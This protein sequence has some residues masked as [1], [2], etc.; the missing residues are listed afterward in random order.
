[1]VELEIFLQRHEHSHFRHSEELIAGI[2]AGMCVLVRTPY[3][4]HSR[5]PL[6]PCRHFL[7]IYRYRA[8]HLSRYQTAYAC[9]LRED[10]LALCDELGKTLEEPVQFWRF[11]MARYYNFVVFEDANSHRILGCTFSADRRLMSEQEWEE[12][13]GI[14]NE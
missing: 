11:S 13:W 2:R 6:L 1:M 14:E 8:V 7:K 9:S 3:C 12:L 5:R 10:V 4:R